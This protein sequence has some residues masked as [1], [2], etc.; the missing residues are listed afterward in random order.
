MLEPD[1]KKNEKRIALVSVGVVVVVLDAPRLEGVDEG[2]KHEGAHDV[3]EQLV[4][5]EGPVPGIVSNHKELH[6]STRAFRQLPIPQGQREHIEFAERKD[7]NAKTS[8]R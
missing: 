5:A 7:I 6:Q 4:L 3:L 8:S 1:C 2:R